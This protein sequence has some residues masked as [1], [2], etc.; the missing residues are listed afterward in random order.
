ML[1]L[2]WLVLHLQAKACQSDSSAESRKAMSIRIYNEGMSGASAPET[3]RA[4]DV[5]RTIGGNRPNQ[6]SGASGEDQVHISSLSESLSTQ[7]VHHSNHVQSLKALYQAGRYHVDAASV[8]HAVVNN[9][10]QSGA[11]G[12]KG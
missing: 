12:G 11:T 1:S 9:A 8:S 4:Q 6:G 3:S 7:S 2:R 5:A 10:I